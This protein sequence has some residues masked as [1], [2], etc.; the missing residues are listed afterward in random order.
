MLDLA[1]TNYAKD[2]FA[3]LERL[4]IEFVPME[5]NL[6]KKIYSNNYRVEDVKCL[7]AKI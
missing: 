4:K 5:A 6:K 2:T 3:Q 7:I 1:S